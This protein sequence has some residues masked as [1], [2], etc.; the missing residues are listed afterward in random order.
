VE[1]IEQK[2]DALSDSVDKRFVEG[3]EHFVERKLNQFMAGDN[4]PRRASRARRL[5]KK[6]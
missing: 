6:R 4:R 5:P 3:S 2:L 1:R